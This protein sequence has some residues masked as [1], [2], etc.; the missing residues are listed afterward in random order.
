MPPVPTDLGTV[1]GYQIVPYV[2]TEP[3]TGKPTSIAWY[4]AYDPVLKETV[5]AISPDNLQD[6]TQGANA[7]R[8]QAS[9]LRNTPDYELSS[10]TFVYQIMKGDFAGGLGTLA[11]SWGDAFKSPNWWFQATAGVGLGGAGLL[12]KGGVRKV[13]ATFS[14]KQL[15]K[16]FK[17]AIDFGINTTKKNPTTLNQFKDAM[18]AHLHNSSTIQKGT[19]G[20]VKDS[21]VFFNDKTNNV[22]VLDKLGNF[23]TGFKLIPGDKQYIK[24][25]T[26][27]YLR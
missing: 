19:Y 5:F 9:I 16:K 10:S 8:D 7:W 18:I 22:V 14:Q 24:Y 3:G 23:V 6:F 13:F 15:G 11:C 20:F 26:E 25:M 12:I 1:A 27:G 21:K 17:H 2:F 4:G